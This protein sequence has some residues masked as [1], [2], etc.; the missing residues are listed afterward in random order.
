MRKTVVNPNLGAPRT[1]MR[2]SMVNEKRGCR[3]APRETPAAF[4]NRGN[5]HTMLSKRS[6]KQLY[7]HGGE[8]VGAA[9]R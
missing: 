9:Q 5:V 3:S 2:G 8:G 7:A 1:T 4:L 6:G